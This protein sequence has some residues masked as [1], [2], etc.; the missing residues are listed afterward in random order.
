[1]S[2]C[3]QDAYRRLRSV[4]MFHERGVR[5]SAMLAFSPVYAAFLL[6]YIYLFADYAC[7][8][9][10]VYLRLTPPS[11]LPPVLPI[12]LFSPSAYPGSSSLACLFLLM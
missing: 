7:L 2:A 10:H 12:F 9:F 5:D 6:V 11:D 4:T 8:L 1:M 3:L